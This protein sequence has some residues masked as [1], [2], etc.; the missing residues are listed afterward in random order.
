MKTQSHPSIL[1]TLAA[2]ILLLAAGA[3]RAVDFHVAT[4]QDLQNALTVASSNGADDNIYLAAG[5]YMGNFNF[6]S[7]EAKNLTLQA[8]AGVANDQITIDG[9][10]AGRTMSLSCSTNA[11]ITVRGL[12]F[13][14]N[15]GSISNASLRVATGVAA[16][17]LVADCRFLS[18]S[19]TSGMGIELASS[20][21]ATVLRCTVAGRPYNASYS[22]YTG[23]GIF[24]SGVASNVSV[25]NCMVSTNCVG[26]DGN[27]G[28]GLY[29]GSGSVVAV[30]GNIFTGNSSMHGGGAYVGSS[31]YSGTVAL[32]GNIFT[33]NSSSNSLYSG[34]GGGGA[35]VHSSG[36]A[37]LSGNMFNRNTT[38]QSGGAIYASGP[39]VKL[40]NNLILSNAQTRG[41]YRG[42]GVWVNAKTNLYMVN[43]TL[44]SNTAAGSGGGMAFQV[45][46]V[47]ETL[48]VYN[49]IIWGNTAGSNGA[50]VHLAGTGQRK[51]FVNNDAS[52]LFGIWDLFTGNMDMAPVFADAANGDYHLT[53]GSPCVNAGTNSA[54]QLPATDLDG[55]P[56][57]A[58]GRVDMGAYEFSNTDYHPA[59]V[60]MNWIVE[61]GEFTT[62]SNAWRSGQ[63]W[64]TSS[65]SIPTDYVT[66]AGY[67]MQSGGIYH[68]DG[69]ARPLRWKPGP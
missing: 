24:I 43:N 11:A 33:G 17:V 40:L 48:Q 37:T 45:D 25:Q 61:A 49:N 38:G 30:S 26:N 47:T 22:D 64:G 4:A 50:D 57:I 55:D 3:A 36:A 42:G 5:Y 65:N 69:A 31:S 18:P 68:N 29:I 20:L 27:D 1:I 32:S 62:Y 39:T 56:R 8:E 54:P 2:V 59:D 53:A 12:T 51:E 41:D 34:G 23:T 28:G 9:A 60:N 44:T 21:N 46:G 58:G 66:R 10:G 19:N 7:A 14:R 67:L 6:N 35:C 15:C 13:L 63:P 52:G 16:N